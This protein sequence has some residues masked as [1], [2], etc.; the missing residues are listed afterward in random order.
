MQLT[1][2]PSEGTPPE[3]NFIEVKPAHRGHS[4]GAPLSAR[5]LAEKLVVLLHDHARNRGCLA[6]CT[7]TTPVFDTI[8]A[9]RH[10]MVNQWGSRPEDVDVLLAGGRETGAE[11]NH[12]LL[13]HLRRLELDRAI[14]DARARPSRPLGTI[15]RGTPANHL[16]YYPDTAQV[17]LV[18]DSDEP[19]G[20]AFQTRHSQVTQLAGA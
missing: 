9:M 16:F 1:C 10:Y 12:A 11:F 14:H 15:P 8:A 13:A 17:E 7:E 2:I 5:D 3:R 18:I 4:E 19:G 20:R 6:P